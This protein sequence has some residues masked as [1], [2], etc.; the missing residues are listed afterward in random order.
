MEELRNTLH[1]KAESYRLCQ[2]LCGLY[3]HSG[4]CFQYGVGQCKGACIGKELPEEYNKRVMQLM[5]AWL[6]K[7]QNF[8]IVGQGRVF[9]EKS[10]VAIEGGKYLGFGYLE[11]DFQV[12][13]PEQLKFFINPYSDNRDVHTIIRTHMRK[14]KDLKVIP[15]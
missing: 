3:D 9:N 4:A 12:T 5:R 7:H 10:V 8:L 11:N 6:Y 1:E 2:K 15:Y 13:N 14:N